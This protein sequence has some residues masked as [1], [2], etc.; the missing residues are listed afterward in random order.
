MSEWS[1][2]YRAVVLRGD[3]AA[4]LATGTELPTVEL[5]GDEGELAHHGAA[6]AEALAGRLSSPVEVLRVV[7]GDWDET[8]RR[9]DLVVEVDA[10]GVRG[11]ARRGSG[12]ADWVERGRIRDLAA[13]VRDLVATVLE[14]RRSGRVPPGRA[15]WADVAWRARARAWIAAAAEGAGRRLERLEVRRDW[16]LSLVWYAELDTG[17]WYAKAG[18]PLPRFV[19]EA[20]VTAGLAARYPG[21]IVPPIAHDPATG[22]FVTPDQ[23]DVVDWEAPATVKLAFAREHAALQRRSADGVEEL[24]ALGCIDRR[25]D[26]LAA[27]LEWLLGVPELAFAGLGREEVAGI[28]ARVPQLRDALER[29]DR[30]P[31][32]PTL[33]HG[34]AHLGNAVRFDGRLVL[35]DWTDACVAHPFVDAHLLVSHHGDEGLADGLRDVTL[36]AWSDLA[37]AAEL[38][39]AWVW[40]APVALLHHVVSYAVILDGIEPVGR[41]DL[42]GAVPRLWRRLVGALE[43]LEDA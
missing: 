39:R 6:L 35:I 28:L 21:H 13:D 8:R 22:L 4:V 32:P 3:G 25:G 1:V 26:V 30:G 41:R 40:A 36:E 29:V 42:Q 43:A 5:T 17:A 38:R 33:V 11:G 9:G 15:P 19:D 37:T 7:A 20:A 18:L 14:E 31:V 24:L 27:D 16:A 2:R 34:D 12:D 10:P 23:G